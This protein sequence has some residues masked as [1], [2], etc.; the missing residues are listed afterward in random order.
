MIRSCH[1]RALAVLFVVVAM[2]ATGA[3]GTSTRRILPRREL[4][5]VPPVGSVQQAELGETI[6]DKGELYTYDGLVLDNEVSA[7]DGVF[8]LEIT[9]AP[10]VLRA[11]WESDKSIYYQ[12]D[13]VTC[14]D[15]L[16]GTA[17]TLGG[18]R[19]RKDDPEDIGIWGRNF[20]VNMNPDPDPVLRPTRV[21]AL[22]RPGFRQELIYNGRSGSI[23]KFL[24]REFVAGYVRAPYTQDVQYDLSTDHTIGFKGARIEVLEATNTMLRYRVIQSFPVEPG[25]VPPSQPAPEP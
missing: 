10:Q 15:A 13:N 21:Q 24:Y 17:A 7:G 14:Y 23:L 2:I 11:T 1:R 18:L 25:L 4:F 22:D 5:E 12:G 16:L 9:V 20:D 6:L 8:T 19:I 3:C